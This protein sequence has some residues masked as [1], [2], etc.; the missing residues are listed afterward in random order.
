MNTNRFA[1]KRLIRTIAAAGALAITATGL[2]ACGDSGSTSSGGTTAAAGANTELSA[3]VAKMEKPLD[4]YPVPTEPL[5]GN[6]KA[7]A[8]KTLYYIPITQQSPQF[9]VTQQ[10]LEKAAKTVGMSVQVC[11]G[12]GTPTDVSACVGQATKAEAATIISDA[13]PYGLAANA[14]DAAQAAGIPVII[15]NQVPDKAHPDSK[16]LTTIAAGGSEMQVAL[17][18]WMTLDSDGQAHVLINQSTDGPSPAV[19][20]QAGKDAFAKNCPDCKVTV[21]EISSANFALIPSSTS[22]ALLKDPSIT[23]VD[24][25]FEQYLQATQSGVQS[26]NKTTAVKG[27]VGA[28]QLSGLQQLKSQ[29]FLY[30]AA[31]QASAYQGWVDVD[32]ALRMMLAQ[33][34][35]AYTIPVR[36]FTRESIKDVPLTAEAQAS[37]EWFGPTT[38]TT[39]F[40]KLWGAV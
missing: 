5:S 30:A 7:V 23:Y 6:V 38:F 35:P 12:K 15:S 14:F 17:A 9:A 26:A 33:K 25:Q 1:S 8:G 18:D 16:T 20:V 2:A 31:A 32:A 11:D 10:A 39:D 13:I 24:S 3:A 28:A 4:A 21:N 29:N 36:L 34:V 40:T 19:F 37:G 22:S 27:V